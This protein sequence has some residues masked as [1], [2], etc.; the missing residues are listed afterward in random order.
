MPDAVPR[1]CVRADKALDKLLGDM[2]RLQA[3]SIALTEAKRAAA[4]ELQAARD[5]IAS[6]RQRLNKCVLQ[7]ASR[8]TSGD[9]GALTLLPLQD[10]GCDGGAAPVS[11]L[12]RGL[13]ARGGAGCG[14]IRCVPLR[15]RALSACNAC[16]CLRAAVEKLT[17]DLAAA[18]GEKQRLT[19]QLQSYVAARERLEAE[20][21]RIEKVPRGDRI[22]AVRPHADEAAA[23]SADGAADPR[24]EPAAARRGRGLDAGQGAAPRHRRRASAPVA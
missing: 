1:V 19:E 6:L 20:Y 18:L 15:R 24:G 13:A 12:V 21:T 8:G 10:R 22:A 7:R 3:E 4:G 2:E 11:G 9:I 17:S 16:A 5:E 23:R 14:A